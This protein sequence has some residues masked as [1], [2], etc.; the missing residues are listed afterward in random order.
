M[1]ARLAAL[2]VLLLSLASRSRAFVAPLASH[3]GFLRPMSAAPALSSEPGSA[4]ET[5][6]MAL[7]RPV[8]TPYPTKVAFQGEPGAYSEKCLRELL[9]PNVVAVGRASFDDV[10][11]AVSSREVDYA[12]I[13]IENSLGGSI[14]ANYDLL[15]RY[16]LFIIG[17]HD[18]RVEHTLMALPGTKMKDIKQVS[19]SACSKRQ[20]TYHTAVVTTDTQLSW[21]LGVHRLLIVY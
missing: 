17:E 5:P 2:C 11:R 10:F 3:R 6:S 19:S 7:G 14:H 15:L 20:Y 21:Q 13:P 8:Q 1:C 4:G 9:G 18:F 16:E 12:V